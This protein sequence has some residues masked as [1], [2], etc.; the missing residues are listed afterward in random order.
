MGQ[1]TSY[2]VDSLGFEDS[3]VIEFVDKFVL[4]WR[5]GFSI[6]DVSVFPEK[7]KLSEAV[8]NNLKKQQPFFFFY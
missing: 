3:P 8:E 2:F 7:V 4:D 1:K 5:Y 6:L